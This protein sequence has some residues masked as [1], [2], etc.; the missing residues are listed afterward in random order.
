MKKESRIKIT[1]VCNEPYRVFL[2][3][4]I[5]GYDTKG[6]YFFFALEWWKWGIQL[7]VQR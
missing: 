6:M 3:V 5:V 7:K 1:I 4:L 2:P